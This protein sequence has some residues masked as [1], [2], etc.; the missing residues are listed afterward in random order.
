MTIQKKIEGEVDLSYDHQ[1]AVNHQTSFSNASHPNGGPT[2]SG[3]SS[4][5]I[6]L[7]NGIVSGFKP[8]GYPQKM[9]DYEPK[10]EVPRTGGMISSDVLPDNGQLE[11]RSDD[12]P[13][14]GLLHSELTLIYLLFLRV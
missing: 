1:A 6:Y 9:Y 14:N 7:D 11:P 3:R 12:L 5:P 2:S 8:S 4:Y 10:L 13:D